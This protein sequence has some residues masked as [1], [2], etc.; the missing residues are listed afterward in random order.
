M[1]AGVR[2]ALTPPF[3][4][5]PVWLRAK[6]VPVLDFH[7]AQDLTIRDRITGTQRFTYSRSST[8]TFIGPTGLV[9]TAAINTPRFEYANGVALGLM[10]EGTKTNQ[11]NF[12]ET[13]ATA[14]GT[15]NN[16]ADTNITRN[17]T[18]NTAPDGAASALRVTASAGNA[19]II[20]TAA[21]GSSAERAA[22]IWLRRVSGSGAIQYTTN[23][24]AAW[25]SV[26]TV[27]STWQRFYF[28]ATTEDQRFGIRIVTSGDSIELWGAQIEGGGHSSYVPCGSTRVTRSSDVF[29]LSGSDFSSMWRQSAGTM[30]IEGQTPN[31]IGSQSLVLYSAD[32]NATTERMQMRKVN[33]ETTNWLGIT[34][35][36]TQWNISNAANALPTFTNAKYA[37]AATTNDARS[38]LN[39]TLANQDTSATMPNPSQMTIGYGQG[40]AIAWN[41]TFKRVIY[42]RSRLSDSVLQAITS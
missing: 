19:T 5:D 20:A 21:V 28:T 39:G 38:C 22:S 9:Q 17:S 27:T 4:R 10:I 36:V 26:G 23:N 18:T 11:L 6:A 8:G 13:F 24:G 34:G 37:G 3:V 2:A 41:G 15:N 1:L 29:I 32:N 33:A 31:N 30:Y 7:F 25:T 14:G 40:A 16:W 35:G 42:W 12:S